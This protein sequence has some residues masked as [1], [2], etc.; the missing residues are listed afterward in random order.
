[1]FDPGGAPGLV[2]GPYIV[3]IDRIVIRDVKF[4][5]EV[6]LCGGAPGLVMGP[7]IVEIDHIVIRDVQYQFEVNRCRNEEVNFQGSSANS[8]GGDSGQDGRT[9]RQT[10]D[11]KPVEK[12]LVRYSYLSLT[13]GEIINVLDKDLEYSGLWCGELNGGVRTFPDNF[14]ELIKEEFVLMSLR[15]SVSPSISKNETDLRVFVI[16][17]GLRNEI[18]M[19]NETMIS[20]QYNLAPPPPVQPAIEG[21]GL[22]HTL[23]IA[24]QRPTRGAPG[25]VMGPYIVEIDRIVIRDVQFQFEVNLCR[26]KELIVKGIIGWAWSM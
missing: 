10:D 26:N 7:Y 25:L 22:Y 24:R 4:Q 13:E 11:T 2:M 1:M 16:S 21:Q 12:A 17:F 18:M 20:L 6:N 19:I 15:L 14:V 8:V 3:E 23:K 5:F 9:D